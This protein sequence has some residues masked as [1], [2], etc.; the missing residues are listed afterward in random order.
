[1]YDVIAYIS[2]S[3]SIHWYRSAC[4]PHREK[5]SYPF[6]RFGEPYYQRGPRQEKLVCGPSGAKMRWESPWFL[7]MLITGMPVKEA[8]EGKLSGIF[9]WPMWTPVTINHLCIGSDRSL[10]LEKPRKSRSSR[11]RLTSYRRWHL[12]WLQQHHEKPRVF[13][14]EAAL[15]PEL[16]SSW[17]HSTSLVCSS[18]PRMLNQD[19][20]WRPQIPLSIE[21]QWTIRW[22]EANCMSRNVRVQY[23]LRMGPC[24]RNKRWLSRSRQ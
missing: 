5:L 22:N 23:H 13:C 9:S 3:N 19:S 7:K 20:Q 6:F 15:R 18:R 4:N 16:D 1:M 10:F 12:Q 17:Y 2:C 8:A 14:S 11:E 21:R 24:R